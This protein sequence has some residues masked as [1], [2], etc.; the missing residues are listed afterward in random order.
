MAELPDFW[1]I[2]T[3]HPLIVHFPV[4]MLPV[5]AFFTTFAHFTTNRALA[6]TFRTP[7]LA[8]LF[9]GTAAAWL[10]VYTGHFGA[11]LVYQQAAGVHTPS[12][13]CI[14]FSP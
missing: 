11:T 13:I 5:A 1:R 10:A 3:L 7:T 9:I 2:E 4:A 14:E 12:S 6:W 8:L